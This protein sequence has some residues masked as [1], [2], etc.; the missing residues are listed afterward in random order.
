MPCVS[1]PELNDREL[2]AHI[3]GEAD[4]QV[5]AH[6][7]RCAHCRERAERLARLQSRLMAQLYRITCPSPEELGEYHL[8]VLPRDRAAAV[9]RHLA[10]CPH[11]I[12]E[13]AQ[14]K[15]YLAQMAPTL[16]P[17]PLERF[18]E[19]ARVLVAR[20]IGVRPG[21]SLLK[22]PAL[23]P[24]Y[25]GVRGEEEGPYIYQAGDVQIAI[26][27][28]DD[29]ERPGRKVIFGLVTGMDTGE[30]QVHLRQAG[31]RVAVVPVDELGNFVLPNLAPGTYDLVLT[32]PGVEIHVQELHV[33]TP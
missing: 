4:R 16:E 12:R 20:L 33:E 3:D 2:L 23:A 17:G 1:P 8:G 18:R 7:E 27:V 5:E 26:G 10:R 15:D 9:A 28:Q 32:S 29:A 13:V 21:G 22:R 6:L 14:L 24:A 19:Q 31:Q 25:A 11:C 30:A